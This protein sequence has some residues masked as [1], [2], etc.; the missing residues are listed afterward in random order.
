MRKKNKYNRTGVGVGG[1][2]PLS[3]GPSIVPQYIGLLGSVQRMLANNSGSMV[4]NNTGGVGRVRRSYCANG[5]VCSTELRVE[6][7]VMNGR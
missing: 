3:G 2:P 7:C 5:E 4:A 6:Y 1:H